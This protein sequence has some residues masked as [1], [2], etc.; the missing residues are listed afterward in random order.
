MLTIRATVRDPIC[1]GSGRLC[2]AT[3]TLC[4]KRRKWDLATIDERRTC[5]EV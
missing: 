2:G 5:G 3:A 4:L 1:A